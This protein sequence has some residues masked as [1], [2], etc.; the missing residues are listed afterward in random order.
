MIKSL[1]LLPLLVISS[2][3]WWG[4]AQAFVPSSCHSSLSPSVLATRITKNTHAHHSNTIMSATA[5]TTTASETPFAVIVQA[6]IAPDRM[7]EF[8]R[9]IEHNAVETR[10]EPECLRF[11]V[12]RVQ[13]APNKFFFY[14]VYTSVAAIDHHKKQPHY[15]QWTDFKE[16]G[17]TISSVSFKTDAAFL[18]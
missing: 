6:E 2:S 10:K 3:F 13:E 16:S 9:M 8:L 4:G 11:D 17:G 15:I 1:L 5:G 14:E 7:E 12:L 18:T